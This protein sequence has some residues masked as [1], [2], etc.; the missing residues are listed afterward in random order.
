[1]FDVGGP[2][3]LFLLLLALLVFGPRRLPKIGRKLGGFVGEMRRS[4]ADFRGNLEREVAY[5]EMREVAQGLKD[6]GRGAK[7]ATRG[8]MDADAGAWRSPGSQKPKPAPPEA[9][10]DPEAPAESEDRSGEA[11]TAYRDAEAESRRGEREQ[12][13][14]PSEDRDD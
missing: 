13:G 3:F 10:P 12:P 8:L 11:D 1:M 5:E 2:E 4:L 9:S 7:D 6:V 14:P